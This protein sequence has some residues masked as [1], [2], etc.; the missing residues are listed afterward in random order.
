MVSKN[1]PIEFFVETEFL[2]SISTEKSKEIEEQ[3][4]IREKLSN[5]AKESFEMQLSGLN[6]EFVD[7]YRGAKQ[8]LSSGN[9]DIIRHFTT[10]L[11]EFFTHVLH[12]LSPD[13]DL[14]DWDNSPENFHNGR[15]TRKAHLRF[16]C[17]TINYGSFTDFVE[18][19]IMSVVEFLDIFQK[20]THVVGV[21]FT[22]TQLETI[23]L[24]MEQLLIF[25]IQVNKTNN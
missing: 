22:D 11:R 16:I 14:R 5:Q 18:S 7:L 19:D 10:S 15:P 13:E 8:A 24:R 23:L 2:K 25:L 3:D 12:S 1:P 20:G 9:P 21:L 4:E 17:R 6:A